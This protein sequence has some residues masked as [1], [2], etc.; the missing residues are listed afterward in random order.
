MRVN[1]MTPGAG[2]RLARHPRLRALAAIAGVAL[3]VAACAGA[4]SEQVLSTVGNSVGAGTGSAGRGA[5]PAGAPELGAYPGTVQVGGVS[6]PAMAPDASAAPSLADGGTATAFKD[7]AKVVK[8]GSLTLEVKAL[9][10][11]LAAART[12]IVGLGGYVSGSDESNDG[13]RTRATIVYRIPA[14]RWDDALA[15]LRHLATKVVGERTN[16]V[17]VTSQVIDLDARVRNLRA[18]EAALQAIMAKATKISDILDV[19]Q[20]LTEV[21]GQIEQLSTE[22]AHLVDQ[23]ALGTLAVDFSVPVAAVTTTREGWDPGAEV[24]RAVAGLVGIGQ[25]IASFGIW[26]G[27]VVLP[28]VVVLLILGALAWAAARRM[29]LGRGGRGLLPPATQTGTIPEAPIV[30]EA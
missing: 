27:I 25:G 15:A 6:G 26:L 4:S 24:D 5:L 13:D 1:V 8:T 9:D 14:A 11:A 3:V 16:A 23:A 30:P 19:Q 28:V 18:T 10:D 2:R 17:E 12:A 20:Q 21:R 22:Q 29:G 7:D